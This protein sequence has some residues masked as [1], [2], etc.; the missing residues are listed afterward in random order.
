VVTGG[1]LTS[2]TDVVTGIVTVIVAEPLVLVGVFHA[3]AGSFAAPDQGPNRSWPS[4][5]VPGWSWLRRQLTARR[6][7]DTEE[8]LARPV[9]HLVR[10]VPPR[11]GPDLRRRE[12][13]G[14]LRIGNARLPPLG[15]DRVSLSR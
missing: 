10:V 9:L 11:P 14:T 6:L 7:T 15:G 1:L 5:D 8:V 12:H 4:Y 2:A 13:A 3:E